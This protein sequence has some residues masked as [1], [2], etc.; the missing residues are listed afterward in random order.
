MNILYGKCFKDFFMYN[1]RI[2]D[3]IFILKKCF[4]YVFLR[5]EML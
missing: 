4:Y 2:Y 1:S 5:F 3:I